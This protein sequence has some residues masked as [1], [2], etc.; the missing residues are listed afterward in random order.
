M[1]NKT[2]ALTDGVAKQG[3][4]LLRAPKGGRRPSCSNAM[5]Q[6]HERLRMLSVRTH[7][8]ETHELPGSWPKA[9]ISGRIPQVA[10]EIWIR[11]RRLHHG[12]FQKWGI[13]EQ[14]MASISRNAYEGKDSCEGGGAKKGK[15]SR[16][17]VR[18]AAADSISSYE[19]Y[20][21][22]R[23][24]RHSKQ[25]RFNRTHMRTPPGNNMGGEARQRAK[26][27]G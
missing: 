22:R 16:V 15:R 9:R 4:A 26:G 2:L 25:L 11:P 18:R 7:I 17:C 1:S 27:K 23:G 8:Q 5:K 20:K 21:P 10:P 19:W 24:G 14:A 3:R 6:P 12:A 13:D